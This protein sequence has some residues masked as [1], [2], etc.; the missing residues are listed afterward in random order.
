[1]PALIAVI[2]ASLNSL[3]R[4]PHA[5]LKPRVPIQDTVMPDYLV[6]LENGKRYKTLKGHLRRLGLTP[7][8]Y[9]KKWNLP[10][11]YPVVSADY[12]SHRSKIAKEIGLGVR[13][14]KP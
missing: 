8:Q 7:D 10:A 1:M 6:S 13:K 2:A 5:E 12:S 11:D 4:A 14:R 9:R 3:A